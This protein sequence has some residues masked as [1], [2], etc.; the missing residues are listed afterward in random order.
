MITFFAECFSTT[1]K[2][3]LKLALCLSDLNL[4]SVD[5][6]ADLETFVVVNCFVTSS[7][8]VLK[9]GWL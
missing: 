3:L 2:Q 4:K 7:T 8:K 1:V 6:F 9:I 5:S